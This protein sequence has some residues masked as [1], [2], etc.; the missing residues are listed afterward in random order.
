MLSPADV[1]LVRREAGL[2]GLG[3]VLDADLLLER[4][5]RAW[6]EADLRTARAVYLRYKPHT[7][8]LVAYRVVG[9][10]GEQDVH[11][12]ARTAAANDKIGKAQERA[13][14]RSRRPELFVLDDCAVVVSVFPEDAR[15]PVLRRL[16]DPE[17]RRQLLGRLLHGRPPLGHLVRLR[18]KP[19]R[20]WVGRASSAEAPDVVL[21]AHA[22]GGFEAG[23]RGA[24]F[25]QS[26]PPVVVPRL[27]G[28]LPGQG[29]LAFEWV[30]GRPLGEALSGGE[31]ALQDVR[32][33]G[34]ALAHVHAAPPAGV[35]PRDPLA[36]AHH[37]LSVAAMLAFAQPA[38][39]A[40]AESLGREIAARVAAQPPAAKPVHG[41]FHAGQVL[42][43]GE[44]VAML[45]FD[46]AALA[47]PAADLG[48]FL[49]HLEREACSGR[50]SA[51][52]VGALGEALLAG[53][54]RVGSRPSDGHVALHV[55]SA[56]LQLA[57]HFFRDRDPAWPER[58]EAALD[59]VAAHVGGGAGARATALV[60]DPLGARRDAGNPFLAAALDPT[61]AQ[62][63]LRSLPELQARVP[64][65]IVRGA[66]VL[67]IKPGRRC[68]IRYDLAAADGRG[69]PV[70]VLGKVRARGADLITCRLVRSL[71]ERG[72]DADS[73]DGVS[74]PR[75]FGA[76]L[77]LGMWVQARVGGAP[78]T[79]L[80]EGSAGPALGMRLA[81]ALHKLHRAPI[82]PGRKH[83]AG[84][85]LAIVDDRLQ[86]VAR[87]QPMWAGRLARLAEGCAGAAARLEPR[88]AA[89]IHRDFYADQ[90]MVD[91]DRLYLLDLDLCAAGEPALDVGNFVGHLVEQA[92]RDHGDPC[93]L[94]HVAAA[95]VDR[96]LTRDERTTAAAVEAYTT[97][98]LARHVWLSTQFPERRGTTAALLDLCERR[99]GLATYSRHFAVALG[100]RCAP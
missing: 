70:V 7:S 94:D 1:A 83:T 29:L 41:D 67:R 72:F 20:R 10:Q 61:F 2:P 65:L 100:N 95:L 64:G 37:V 60:S 93:A 99:L 48:A 96:F 24:L 51:D 97:L 13:R 91:R 18:Y 86:R 53:Y 52:R 80:L 36:D 9:P 73:A 63:R 27:L 76:L 38:L 78:A 89:L 31:A 19:E 28:A 8:C 47:D 90:V 4:L 58:T 12:I 49:A 82:S 88:G 50:L 69:E 56:L 92:L 30:A 85:E 23:L 39:A 66:R 74:V 62:D 32:L 15:L 46:E 44:T 21:K 42:L 34:E 11:A 16:A 71:C 87:E 6:P 17:R 22:A 68:L 5:A 75:P 57:P 77:E 81:D 45:D 40:R 55:A 54:G 43:T 33:T 84:D 14:R 98:T 3:L 79:G 26:R 35:L 59:R 25:G